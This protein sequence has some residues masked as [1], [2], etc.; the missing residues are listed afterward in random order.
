MQDFD[1]QQY[2]ISAIDKYRGEA[3]NLSLCTYVV[4]KSLFVSRSTLFALFYVLSGPYHS[5][6]SVQ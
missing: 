3:P 2:F 4:A 6:P 1:H 5:E